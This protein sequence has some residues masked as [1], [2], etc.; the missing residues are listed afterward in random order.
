[1]N[2]CH[3]STAT[4]IDVLV[5]K[6]FWPRIQE[7]IQTSTKLAFVHNKISQKWLQQKSNWNEAALILQVIHFRKNQNLIELFTITYI[8]ARTCM[9]AYKY[10][11]F[12]YMYTYIHRGTL[13]SW[14][15]CSPMARKNKVQSQIEKRKT[16]KTRTKHAK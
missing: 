12:I 4:R 6:V 16:P 3:Y 11:D 2:L 14:V 13:A 1:M 10:D 7:V 8:C 15:E 5:S 9:H